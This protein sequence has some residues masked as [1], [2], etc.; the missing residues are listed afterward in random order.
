MGDGVLPRNSSKQYAGRSVA[1]MGLDQI[2][3]TDLVTW[4]AHGPI[5]A[6]P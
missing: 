5:G 2:L 3:I 6:R 1:S 4:L